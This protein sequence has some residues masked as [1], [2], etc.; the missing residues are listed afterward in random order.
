[1]CLA[2]GGIGPIRLFLR[3]SF[4]QRK[5]LIVLHPIRGSVGVEMKFYYVYVLA[6]RTRTLYIGVTSDLERRM[7]Q[8][9]TGSGSEHAWKYREFRLVYYEEWSDVTMAIAREKQLKGWRR[10]KKIRLIEEFNPEWKNLASSLDFLLEE[11]PEKRRRK[12]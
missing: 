12:S 5:R 6:S 8:H 11:T 1:M 3:T 9:R 7:R 4:H 2:G 10:S